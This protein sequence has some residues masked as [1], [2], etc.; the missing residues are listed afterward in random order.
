VSVAVGARG[1]RHGFGGRGGVPGAGRTVRAGRPAP[2]P[3]GRA[4]Q[5][6]GVHSAPAGVRGGAANRVMDAS[7]G[8]KVPGRP[9]ACAT[10]RPGAIVWPRPNDEIAPLGHAGGAP[11]HAR[12]LAR[13]AAHGALMTGGRPPIDVTTGPPAE[14]PMVVRVWRKYRALLIVAAV[15]WI[16]PAYLMGKAFKK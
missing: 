7:A 10:L 16:P 14:P 12:S 15:I 1:R 3:A 4:C 9:L 2:D 11:P 6:G 5:S 8:G 13:P